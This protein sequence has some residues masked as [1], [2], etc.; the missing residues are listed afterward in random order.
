MND[1][2]INALAKAIANQDAKT[3]YITDWHHAY[4]NAFHAIEQNPDLFT[5]K[6]TIQERGKII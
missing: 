2:Q 5:Y 6:K 1:S 4:E 3:G